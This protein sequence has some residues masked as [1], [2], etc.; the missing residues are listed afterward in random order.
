MAYQQSQQ[1][2]APTQSLLE[3]MMKYYIQRNDQLLQRNEQLIQGQTS[4]FRNLEV[5]MGQLATNLRSCLIGTLS[6]NIKAPK[7]DGK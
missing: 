4:F 7:R 1:Q 6:S 5:Q 2:V 3:L